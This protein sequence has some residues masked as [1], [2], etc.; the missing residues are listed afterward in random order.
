[1]VARELG[2]DVASVPGTRAGRPGRGAR[3]PCGRCRRAAGS[4]PSQRHRSGS[5]PRRWR[6]SSPRSTASTWPRSPGTGPGGRIT[7]KDVTAFV[8]ARAAAPPHAVMPPPAEEAPATLPAVAAA[9]AAFQPL[10]P[11]AADHRRPDGGLGAERGARDDPDGSGHDRGGPL[12]HAARARVREAVRRPT[13]VRRD[14]R[15]GVR[16][17]AGRASARQRPVAGGRRRSAGRPAAPAERERRDRGS[18]GGRV[19]GRRRP[20][21]R[22][23]AALRRSTRT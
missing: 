23:E 22:Q 21:R 19:A 13:G 2:I 11:G 7:E 18:G 1:M 8:E 9:T 4:R 15:Q 12:P 3:R 17:R 6:A 5:S 10:E 20:R 16:D 14:D